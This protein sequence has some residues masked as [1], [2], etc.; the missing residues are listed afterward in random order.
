MKVTSA[1]VATTASCNLLFCLFKY[2][3]VEDFSHISSSTLRVGCESD[4]TTG[5]SVPDGIPDFEDICH[6][7]ATERYG[8]TIESPST[9]CKSKP[10]S[11]HRP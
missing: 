5:G 6:D 9:L 4:G 7:V 11:R 2:A 8:V 3:D 1:C 10:V